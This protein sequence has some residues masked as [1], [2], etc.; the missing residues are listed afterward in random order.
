MLLTSFILFIVGILL[1]FISSKVRGKK[2]LKPE[3]LLIA[4]L[5]KGSREFAAERSVGSRSLH[6]IC[7]EEPTLPLFSL[8]LVSLHRRRGKKKVYFL[9]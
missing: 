8:I 9:K 7:L 4:V 2:K 3:T 6:S 5:N 1:L